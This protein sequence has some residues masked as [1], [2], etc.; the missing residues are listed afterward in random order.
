MFSKEIDACASYSVLDEK[1]RAAG[2]D[3]NKYTC[4]QRDIATPA[5][6][7][8]S[9]DAGDKMADS[10]VP[11]LHCGTHAPGWLN[12][13]HPVNEGEVVERQACF[14]WGSSCCKWSTKI[15]IKKCKGFFVYEL[16]RTPACHLRYCG[17]SGLRKWQKL[18]IFPL[19]LYVRPDKR[20][21][22]VSSGIYFGVLR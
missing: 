2:N 19:N 1:D 22:E 8:F 5:W 11:Q 15:K 7:R 17:N 16:Q 12:G 10:C 6:Y 14:H 9:E 20:T 18:P 4:D 3:A 13:D 21:I